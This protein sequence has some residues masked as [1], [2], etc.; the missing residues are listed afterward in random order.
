MVQMR[1][2]AFLAVIGAFRAMLRIFGAT[3]PVVGV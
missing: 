1:L 2:S 3:D